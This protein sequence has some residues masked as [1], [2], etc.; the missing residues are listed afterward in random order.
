MT[1]SDRL[2]NTARHCGKIVRAIGKNEPVETVCLVGKDLVQWSDAEQRERSKKT[3]EQQNVRVVLYHELIE[4]AYRTYNSF[5]E[6]HHE[7][8]R[9]YRLVKNLEIQ[10][11]EVD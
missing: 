6:L 1:C 2:K 8:G 10:A 11:P 5:L 9:V 4:D 3:M 7:H